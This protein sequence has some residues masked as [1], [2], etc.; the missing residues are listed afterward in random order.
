MTL[1]T[2]FHAQVLR[3]HLYGV[4]YDPPIQCDN[5][6]HYRTGKRLSGKEFYKKRISTWGINVVRYARVYK[7]MRYMDMRVIVDRMV[8]ANGGPWPVNPTPAEDLALMH[9]VHDA[10]EAGYVG[11]R[12]RRNPP[13][14]QMQRKMKD[15]VTRRLAKKICPLCGTRLPCVEHNVP[16]CKMSPF[17][18]IAVTDGATPA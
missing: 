15:E 9:K 16:L 12:Q 10:M 8:R 13:A 5:L 18:P 6:R 17:G 7:R 11:R 2:L 1:R 3:R 14:V 4:N